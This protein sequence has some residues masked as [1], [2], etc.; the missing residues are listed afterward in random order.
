M[1]PDKIRPLGDRVLLHKC[2]NAKDEGGIILPEKSVDNTDFCAVV[3]VGPKCKVPW[4]IGAIV[5]VMTNFHNDL[6]G[7]PDTD[8]AYWFAREKLVEPVIYG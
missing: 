6:V 5:R 2:V 3:A 7:V 1:E 8:G 4:P